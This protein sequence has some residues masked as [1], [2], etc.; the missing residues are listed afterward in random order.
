MTGTVAAAFDGV[1]PAIRRT[2]AGYLRACLREVG[3]TLRTGRGAAAA[4]GVIHCRVSAGGDGE[5]GR[6]LVP[7]PAREAYEIASSAGGA[8]R[9]VTVSSGSSRGLLYGVCRLAEEIRRRRALPESFRVRT[10]PDLAIR[11]WSTLMLQGGFNLPAGGAFDRPL[12]ELE[13]AVNRVIDR[14]P[15]YGINRLQLPG[16]P[17]EGMDI[18]WL[19]PYRFL[20]RLGRTDTPALRERRDML[21]RIAARAHAHG[22]ELLVWDHELVFPDDI[23]ASYPECGGTDFPVCFSNP[24][25]D[26]FIAGK[27]E[28]FFRLVPEVDGVNLTF[29]ETLRGYN[30]LRDAG[31]RCRVC[32]AASVADKLSRVFDAFERVCAR[33]GRLFE[34]RTYA[35]E[36]ERQGDMVAAAGRLTDAVVMT[37]YTPADFRGVDYPHNPLIG[38]FPAVPQIVEFTLTPECNGF[39]Y[40]PA[41]LGDFYRDRIA[42]ARRQGVAGCVGRV[43]YHLQNS[44]EAF[45]TAG[46]PVLT[47]D[48]E[49]DFN[50]HLFSRLLWDPA[51]DTD[52]LWREW[53][54]ARYGERAPDLLATPLRSTREITQGIYYV[55]GL[56]A[57]S[58]LD[59]IADLEQITWEIDDSFLR[60]F[61]PGEPAIERL[62]A[63]LLDPAEKTIREVLAEKDHAVALAAA[64]CRDVE[65]AADALPGPRMRQLRRRFALLHDTARLWRWIAECYF[66]LRAAVRGTIPPERN[67]PALDRALLGMIAQ[68][69]AM[70]DRHGRVYPVYNACRGI[71]AYRFVLEVVHARAGWSADAADDLW[72][73]LVEAAKRRPDAR[74]GT[75]VADAAVVAIELAGRWLCVRG[76]QGPHARYPLPVEAAPVRLDEPGASAVGVRRGRDTL[77]L[78]VVEGH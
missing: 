58:Q 25:W 33:L 44:H 6:R 52:A 5:G 66:R 78:E 36:R 70:E 41:L 24:F 22:L 73:E 46:P 65:R 48:T 7:D 34:A 20:P 75:V 29:E 68:A 40:V 69:V 9:T 61:N 72:Y 8:V 4:Q 1:D 59:Q 67:D 31:C 45:F 3:C 49:N 62:T 16:R 63:E 11:E 50:V 19:I 77:H 51:A 43:D 10:A 17:G 55:K 30:I 42:H 39:G 76:R 60:R 28:E 23:E 54:A 47:F 27:L 38:M 14:A 12:R 74:S 56:H 26:D 71:T 2:A 13:A 35:L 57:L 53:A 64:A 21:R 15:F 37:K 18:D 32:R